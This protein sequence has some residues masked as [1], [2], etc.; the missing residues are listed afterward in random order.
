MYVSGIAIES[1]RLLVQVEASRA[2]VLLL[3]W[4]LPGASMPE[5]LKEFSELQ[6]PPKVVVLAAKP[7]LKDAALDAGADAF[8]S[9]SYTP[10][11][12]LEVLR[13]MEKTL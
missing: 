5:L 7:E 2:D 12:L 3:D 13:S 10:D 4:Y 11:S 8:V 9:K 1:E 6:S